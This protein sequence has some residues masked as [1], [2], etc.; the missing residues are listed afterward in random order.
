MDSSPAR[1]E[2]DPDHTAAPALADWLS[3]SDTQGP[4]PVDTDALVVGGGIIGTALAYYLAREGVET[5]LLERGEL[6]REASGTNAGS[7]H[8]Q[9]A[10]HQLTGLEVDS[11]ADRLLPEI[12]LYVQA[13]ALWHDLERELEGSLEMHVTGGLMVAETP[14]QLALLHDKQ[15]IEEQA[16]L[17]THVLEGE[18]LRSFAPYLA[19]DL[20]GATFCPLEG[21]ANPL[22]AAPLYALRA[23]G[24]GASIHTHTALTAVEAQPGGGFMVQTSN[25]SI[26]ARRIV[27]AAGAWAGDVA[28]LSGLT[29][30]LHREGLHVNVTEP[31]ER[32]LEP[33]VQHI[34]RRL[35]LKQ[36]LN[37]TF[38]IGGGWPARAQP[39]PARYSTTWESAAGN[40]AVALR[41][42]PR[43]ADVRV[44]RTWSGVMAFTDDLSPIVGESRALPGYFTCV[45][46][47][48][49][50]LGPLMA[51][52]LVEQMTS[53]S[54]HPPLPADFAPDRAP[55]GQPA[56]T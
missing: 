25:G 6:N 37:N 45:A 50:T 27:N 29:L 54:I 35:T 18:E 21:H 10:I 30:P 20:A 11:V 28:A 24:H 3:V 12:R 56:R 23:A 55:A 17:E 2:T 38:I 9:I 7:F 5:V 49:F 40:A 46:T 31:R 34:G 1:P 33:L 15:R 13:A 8:L 26:R 19:D 14:E 39:A 32:F 4:L 22:Y 51:R 36:S 44:M 53:A 47:T 43:L 16:G 42:V 48:G 41:V 52:L